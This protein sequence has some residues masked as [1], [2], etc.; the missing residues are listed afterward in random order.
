MNKI[1]DIDYQTTVEADHPSWVRPF[2]GGK[3]KAFF[4]PSISFGRE[5]IELVQRMDI[6][7]E[8]V[9]IDKNWDLNKWGIADYYHIR[10][11]IWDF[12]VAYKNLETALTSD[13]WFDVLVIPGIN[14][15]GYFGEKTLQAIERRVEQGAG[16]VMI[17]PFKGEGT[18]SVETLD[19]L[20]P[21]SPLFNEGFAASNFGGEG[22]PKVA[23]D[24][25]IKDK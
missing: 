21:L 8:T 2:S 7:F 14:G 13:E 9:T 11:G 6:D 24:K 22:F 20:S 3:L 5:I 19:R 16:L 23:F 25:M 4:V 10:G 12:R 17:K 18:G 15:W 1:Y